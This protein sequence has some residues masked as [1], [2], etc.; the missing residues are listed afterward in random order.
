VPSREVHDNVSA[1]AAATELSM[2]HNRSGLTWHKQ[3]GAFLAHDEGLA[4]VR[5]GSPS[6]ELPRRHPQPRAR[7]VDGEGDAGVLRR[8]L[9]AMQARAVEA[10]QELQERGARI[11][12]PRERLKKGDADM[13]ADEIQ[14]AID[15][16]E[17]K[18][19]ELESQ[20]PDRKQSAKVL[21]MLPKA[22]EL[23]RR[24]LAEGLKG[25]PRAALKA[26]VTLREMCGG[27]IDLKREGDELWAEYGIQPAALVQIV[28]NRG[29]GGPLRAL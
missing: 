23:F 26:R 24:Q 1:A 12:R 27:R 4:S 25:D 14:A 29:S 20:L 6:G 16:A 7:R 22:A 18:R 15:R 19:K 13:A 28:G 10:P 8:R 5:R 3:L 17:E 2:R 9:R 21:S 11:E